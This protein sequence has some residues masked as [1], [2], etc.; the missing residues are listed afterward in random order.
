MSDYK[1]KKSNKY[2]IIEGYGITED[3]FLLELDHRFFRETRKSM[4]NVRPTFAKSNAAFDQ[5]SV[6]ERAAIVCIANCICRIISLSPRRELL[7]HIVCRILNIQPCSDDDLYPIAEAIGQK[8]ADR[9]FFTTGNVVITNAGTQYVNIGFL[10]II[11]FFAFRNLMLHLS[12]LTI[13]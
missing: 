2:S 6:R 4:L 9:F 11:F 7:I 10:I 13:S 1:L 5:M 3:W 12:F 8:I